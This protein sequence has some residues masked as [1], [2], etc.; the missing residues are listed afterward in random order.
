MC[1]PW[2]RRRSSKDDKPSSKA[3]L[4]GTPSKESKTELTTIVQKP[5]VSQKGKV[6]SHEPYSQARAR[7]LFKHYQ[8][9]E[10]T[11]EEVIGSEGME[12]LCQDAQMDMESAKPLVLAWMLGAKELGKFRKKEW[13]DGTNSWQ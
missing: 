12:N 6:P 5:N 9:R 3:P 2:F 4:N 11:N 8:D 7:E 13:D 1:L 10:V